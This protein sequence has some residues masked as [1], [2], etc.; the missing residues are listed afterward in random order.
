MELVKLFIDAYNRPDVFRVNSLP[1]N[2]DDMYEG[3]L[4]DLEPGEHLTGDDVLH[5][6]E[7][8]TEKR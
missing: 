8:I 7:F 6:L 1:E 3:W 2:W 5:L 4:A